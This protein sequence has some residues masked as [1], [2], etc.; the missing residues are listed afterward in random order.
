[1]SNVSSFRSYNRIK[2]VTATVTGC[3]INDIEYS[4]DCKK[5]LVFFG[6]WTKMIDEELTFDELWKVYLIRKKHES[7]AS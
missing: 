6:L 5:E 3:I 7:K 1:M 2:K 4:N